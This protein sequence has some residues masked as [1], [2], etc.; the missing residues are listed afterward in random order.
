[1]KFHPNASP[2]DVIKKGAFGGT[3]FR[4]IYSGVTGKFYKNSWKEFSELKSIDKK[5]YAS[6]FYDVKLDCYGVEVGTSLRFWESKNWIRPI[7]P[8]GWFQWYFRYWKGRRNNDDIRQI[9]R[10]KKLLVDLL[11]F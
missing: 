4:D 2:V 10:W 1:M 5:Y 6:D 9:N 8:Y 3:Y 11:L 7:D